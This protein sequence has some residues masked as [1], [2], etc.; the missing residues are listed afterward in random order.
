MPGCDHPCGST[1]TA[2]GVGFEPTVRL[3]PHGGFQDRCLRPLGQPSEPHGTRGRAQATRGRHDVTGRPTPRSSA[4]EE[5]LAAEMRP[6]CLGHLDAAVGT[7]V[8]LHERD[9]GAL[10]G[11]RRAVEGV[12]QDVVTIR[13]PDAGT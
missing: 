7:L 2:E 10:H 3:T 1:Y 6:E 8:L 9:D 5:H 13:D 4:G 11:Q 12:D